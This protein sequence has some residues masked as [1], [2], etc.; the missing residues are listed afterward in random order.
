MTDT[1]VLFVYSDAGVLAAYSDLARRM[2]LKATEIE[3]LLAL[4][5]GVH[6]GHPEAQND[7]TRLWRQ[8]ADAMDDL[9]A[10]MRGAV[11]SGF[12]PAS[13]AA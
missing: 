6:Y 11:K 12:C 13:L 7:E 9:I 10:K 1:D 8:S 4:W 3:G 2:R 5:A